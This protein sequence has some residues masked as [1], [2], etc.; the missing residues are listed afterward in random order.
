[1]LSSRVIN[2]GVPQGTILGPLFFF[3]YIYDI[4]ENL[5]SIV[6]LFA[7]DTSLACSSANVRDI[8]GILNPDVLVFSIWRKQCLVDFNPSKTKAIIFSCNDA[9]HFPNLP[10]E[11]VLVY[12]TKTRLFKYTENFT[13]KK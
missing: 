8:E 5:L 12:I 7:D 4:V 2:A 10:F 13:T 11:D 3:V 1:M 9:Y 6:R